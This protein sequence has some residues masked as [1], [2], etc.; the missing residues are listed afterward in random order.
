MAP[1]NHS[2]NFGLPG[3]ALYALLLGLVVGALSVF[4]WRGRIWAMI[5]AFAL[6]LAHWIALANINPMLWGS[7]P[8]LAAPA[9]SAVLT[10]IC[11]ALA[12]RAN[13][14]A[15]TDPVSSVSASD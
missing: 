6:S 8:N 2:R 5:A 3:V 15:K 13:L 11:I 7:L 9:V 4:I 14:R 1:F 12:V 10:A